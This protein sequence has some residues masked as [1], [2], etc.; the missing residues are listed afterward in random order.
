MVFRSKRRLSS[1]QTGRQRLL[2]T[3]FLRNQLACREMLDNQRLCNSPLFTREDTPTS[4]GNV[5]QFRVHLLHRASKAQRPSM[6]RTD[7]QFWQLRVGRTYIAICRS[8]RTS[9]SIRRS[10]K[11]SQRSSWERIE[12]SG[13]CPH[14]MTK[15]EITASNILK[16]N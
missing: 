1:S 7:Q 9:S 3:F 6:R 2:H 14:S 8:G 11:R 4:S 12:S 16:L 5:K 13:I 15:G 10:S